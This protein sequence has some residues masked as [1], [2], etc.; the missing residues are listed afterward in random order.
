MLR[1]KGDKKMLISTVIAVALGVAPVSSDSQIV[2]GDYSSQ[3]GRYSQS[4]DRSGTTR[5]RGYDRNGASYELMIDRR[6]FVEAT[7]GDR[8]VTFRVREAA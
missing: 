1:V 4:V 5:L 3:I 7:V 6:G 2:S 8:I